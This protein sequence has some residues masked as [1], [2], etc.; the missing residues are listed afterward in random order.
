MPACGAAMVALEGATELS[1]DGGRKRE[2]QPAEPALSRASQKPP[3]SSGGRN[4]SGSREGNHSS[5]FSTALATGL[6]ATRDS[7]G[8]GARPTSGSVRARA[9][10]PWNESGNAS[11]AGAE[12]CS[13]SGRREKHGAGISRKY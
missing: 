10:A 6:D 4:R 2:T 9:G 1:S 7:T 13:G 8:S 11:G 12:L 3:S 5:F